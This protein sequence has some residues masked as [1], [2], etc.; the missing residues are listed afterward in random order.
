MYN[1][2]LINYICKLT[3]TLIKQLKLYL[4]EFLPQMHSNTVLYAG[5]P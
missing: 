1:L 5:F 4:Y 3:N 2:S